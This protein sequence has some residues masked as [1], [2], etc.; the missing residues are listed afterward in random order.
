MCDTTDYW[1]DGI[2]GEVF[3][4]GKCGMEKIHP[5]CVC[6]CKIPEKGRTRKN[7]LDMEIHK[8]NNNG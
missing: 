2:G 1:K 4:C 8:E 3:M 6:P 5:S 7:K